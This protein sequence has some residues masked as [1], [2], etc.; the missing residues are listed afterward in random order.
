M[1]GETP[2]RPAEPDRPDEEEQDDFDREDG[3]VAERHVHVS[4]DVQIESGHVSVVGHG[5]IYVFGDQRPAIRLDVWRQ[6]PEPETS[7]LRAVASRMLNGR[8]RVVGFTG[9]TEDLQ[10]LRDWR[11]GGPRLNARWLHGDG[12]QGKSRLAGELAAQSAAAGWKVLTATQGQNTIDPPGPPVDL[13]V[14]GHAGVL[15]IVDYANEWRP[16]ELA[17]LLGDGALHQVGMRSRV[18]LIAR[19]PADWMGLRGRLEEQGLDL[20]VQRLGPLPGSERGGPRA[21][22][23]AAARAAFAARYG[24]AGVDRLAPPADLGGPDFGLTLAVHMAALVAV[25]AAAR[26]V[27]SPQAA[28][29]ADLTRYLLDREYKHWES[30]YGDPTHELDP[31]DRTFFTPP[32]VMNRVVFTAALTGPVARAAGAPVITAQ[33]PLSPERSPLAADQILTDHATCYPPAEPGQESVLEPLYPDRLAEDFLALTIPGPKTVDYEPQQWAAETTRL[34]LRAPAEARPPA[35][36]AGGQAGTD[37]DVGSD[38]DAVP[39]WAARA[40][41]FLAAAAARWPH[42]GPGALYRPVTDQPRLALAGGSAALSALAAIGQGRGPLLD[43]GL[44]ALL[45]AVHREFPLG[46]DTD[47]DAGM[48]DVTGRL[49]EHV[50]A[51]RS[52]RVTQVTWLCD[53]GIRL[54]YAGRAEQAA[55]QFAAAEPIARRLARRGRAE[56]LANL[57]F[58]LCHVGIHRFQAGDREAAVAPLEESLLRY[59]WLADVAPGEHLPDLALAAGNLSTVFIGLG[60]YPEALTAAET[61]IASLRALAGADRVAYAPRLGAALGNRG[62]IESELGRYSAALET[63]RQSVALFRELAAVAPAEH[64]PMLAAALSN[65]GNRFEQLGRAKDALEPTREADEI[66]RR[67][68]KA[69][70]AAHRQAWSVTAS[71]LGLRLSNL[72]AKGQAR[73]Y[74]EEAVAA[75]RLLVAENPAAY[76]PDLARYL[77]NLGLCLMELGRLPDAR[78]PMNEA[79][80]SYEM[81][82]E[83][84]PDAYRGR[85]ARA[86]SNVGVLEQKLGNLPQSA[87]TLDRSV[88]ILR[89]LAAQNPDA[90]AQPLVLALHNLSDTLSLLGRGDEAESIA[91]QAVALAREPERDRSAADLPGTAMTLLS[92]ADSLAGQNRDR[93]AAEASGEAVGILRGLARD[94]PLHQASLSVA[95]HNHGIHLVCAGDADGAQVVLEESIALCRPLADDNPAA[96]AEAL[97]TQLFVLAGVLLLSPEEDEKDD[98]DDGEGTEDD[99]EEGA[100]ESRAQAVAA[101]E[102]SAAI[103][104]VAAELRTTATPLRSAAQV[105]EISEMLLD[106]GDLPRALAVSEASAARFRRLAQADPDRYRA[107]SALALSCLCRRVYN[108]SRMADAK[109]IGQEARTIL[110]QLTE[111]ERA[112]YAQELRE[113]EQRIDALGDFDNPWARAAQPARVADNDSD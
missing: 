78:A 75:G 76:L 90:Y 30:Q 106:V 59:R 54:G 68:A 95:L 19:A 27:R 3:P 56:H 43:P 70:P 33:R 100:D 9:R 91:R 13:R 104:G 8:W 72:G 67:L 46:R 48:A 105:N 60:R 1:S 88:A 7:W 81:L 37:A 24:L 102:E 26:G 22:M 77:L 42:V 82:A 36:V 2:D 101:L 49:A 97:A 35:A 6:A 84:L 40:L 96:Y 62:I 89:E 93:E 85:L 23:F 109:A 11:D 38:A 61:A 87:V 66:L 107:A 74:F 64:L 50:L 108:D 52:D 51:G 58:V 16:A 57:A 79:M 113:A 5:N 39:P 20:S 73:E 86:L 32:G 15:L 69:N 92:L 103:Y 18:L 4:Q 98:D 34:V 47:L 12:G 112:G 83:A 94:N 31:G 29:M 65:L 44:L 17:W 110:H 10:Q 25:D 28:G 55:A 14:S 71:N 80:A 45:T 53:S 41:I 111:A 21:E 63:A 99:D